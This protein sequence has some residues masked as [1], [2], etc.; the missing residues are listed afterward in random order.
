MK[1]VAEQAVLGLTSPKAAL[2]DA[3]GNILYLLGRTG[4]FLSL[5]PANQVLPTSSRWRAKAFVSRFQTYFTK[6]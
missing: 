5:H 4:S 6:L 1:S 2:I 3:K